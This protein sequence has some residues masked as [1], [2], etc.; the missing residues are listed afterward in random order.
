MKIIVFDL[1][2]TIGF[3][4]QLG[5]F[6][7]CLKSYN[8]KITKN[9]IIK[10]FD[11]Y[12]NVFRHRIIP[13]L[14]YLVKKRKQKK[15]SKIMI[16]TNNQAEK[17]WVLTIKKYLEEKIGEH[18][19]DRVIAAYKVNGKQIEMCR[20]THN[21]T[22]NDFLKCSKVSKYAKICFID[23][24]KHEKMIHKNITYLHIP[25]YKFGYSFMNMINIFTSSFKEYNTDQFKLYMLKCLKQYE[26][27]PYRRNITKYDKEVT[28]DL[29][30]HLQEFIRNP[31]L[32]KKR[33]KIN[34]RS[35][36]MKRKK[37]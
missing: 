27:G 21:K 15:I 30:A 18:I 35:K 10:I 7:D 8:K 3:F 33:K 25:V 5:L 2:E 11:L 20:T 17:W 28:K 34:A 1:D 36:T 12:P 37:N 22:Y 23:D 9:D 29:I 4:S 26:C 32:T 31:T 24:Q 13:I 19:F 16:Y 14:K 6:I